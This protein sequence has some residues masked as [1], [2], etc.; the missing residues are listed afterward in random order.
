MKKYISILFVVIQ[1]IS[2]SQNTEKTEIEKSKNKELKNEVKANVAMTLFNLPEIS[3]ER[4]LSDNQ[5]VGLAFGISFLEESEMGIKYMF[6]PNY[7]LYFSKKRAAGFFMEANASIYEERINWGYYSPY[8]YYDYSID[9]YGRSERQ[10]NVGIGFSTGYKFITE[11]NWTGEMN[12][13]LGRGLLNRN[14]S[15]AREFEYYPR[16]GFSIGK[17]F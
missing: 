8:Y 11:S 3:Y 17:R 9:W 13:G 4:I 14:T 16:L 15:I 1:S 2:Y 12:V 10:V 6:T 7:R 5:S